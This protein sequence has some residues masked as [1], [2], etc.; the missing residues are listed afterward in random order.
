MG[1]FFNLQLN[2]L[3]DLLLV[4]LNDLYSAE[5]Q[6]CD[7][8]PEMM[9]AATSPLLK[10]AF[11]SHLQETQRQKSRLEQIFVDLGKPAKNITCQAMKGL[12]AE[13][14]EIISAEGSDEVRDAALI[15]AAQ[16][17]E[18][19]EIAGYGTARTFANQLGYDNVVRLLQMTLEEEAQTDKKLTQLAEENVNVHAS[20]K[21]GSSS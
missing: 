2:S 5:Q 17:V 4:E 16:R 20:Q 11:K 13:G 12:I 9:E 21:F 19:Y 1:M 6:L 18:H 15:G 10:A 14:S 7:A 8:L 3:E